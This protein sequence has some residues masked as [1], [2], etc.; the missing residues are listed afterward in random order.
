MKFLLQATFPF[1]VLF[2]PLFADAQIEGCTDPNASNYNPNATVNDGSCTYPQ[3]LYNPPYLYD[4]PDQLEESSGLIFFRNGLWSHNDS[5]GEHSLYKIDTLTHEI[6][7]VI[8][9]TNGSNVDWEALTQ[10]EDNIYIGDFG[11]NSGKRDDL[12]I[13]LINKS[14]IPGSGDANVNAG[15]LNFVYEDQQLPAK[16]NR[17]NNFDCEAMIAAGDSLYLFSKNWGNE[18][19]KV[20]VL[21]KEAGTYT[22]RLKHQ[23]DVKGLVTDASFNENE[24]MV[25]LV[26]YRNQLWVP[27]LYLLFDYRDLEFFSGNKRRIDMPALLSAQTEGISLYDGKKVFLSSEKTNFAKQKVFRVDAGIWTDTSAMQIE[28]VLSPDIEFSIHPNPVHGKHFEIVIENLPAGEFLIELYDTNSRKYLVD[29]IK[30]DQENGYT[31]IVLKTKAFAPGTYIVK[32]ATTN[33]FA[34]RKIIIE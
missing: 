13:Y 16:R 34:T 25:L 2:L 29:E 28:P 5:G 24:N 4:L 1:L 21:P 12:K 31:S 26:G 8:T 23:Y 15:I 19:T 20:Y 17:Q 7:Q 14:D 22:A 27:F 30:Y 10:D 33:A 6:V 18:Q 3:T 9:L 32:L 11:N